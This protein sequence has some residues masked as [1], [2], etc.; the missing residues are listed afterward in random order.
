MVKLERIHLEK[1]GLTKFFSPIEVRILEVLW[2]KPE[3]TS[4]EI[5][6]RC[7]DLSL[8]CI[9]GTLDRLT[10]AG[11]VERETEDGGG[12]MRFLYS[13]TTT[14]QET[15]MKISERILESLVDTFG[16]SVMDAFGKIRVRRRP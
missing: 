5:Q 2:K 1:K 13:P 8:S 10:K 16:L 9:A 4:S 12:R 14:R 15:G 11:F 3:I 6:R 7:P